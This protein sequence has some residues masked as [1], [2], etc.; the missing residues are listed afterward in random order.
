MP[1]SVPGML[2]RRLE[3]LPA[4]RPSLPDGEGEARANEALA[5]QGSV[6][7]DPPEEPGRRNGRDK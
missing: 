4:G 6:S 3:R 2:R 1:G 5:G 7:A